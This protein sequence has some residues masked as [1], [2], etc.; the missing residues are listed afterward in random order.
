MIRIED[1]CCGCP[2]EMCSAFCSKQHVPHFYCDCCGEEYSYDELR[3]VKDEDV[4]L[5]CYVEQ[6]MNKAAEDAEK[7]WENEPNIGEVEEE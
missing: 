6:A 5:D 4:C 2:A 1:D 3:K 7:A